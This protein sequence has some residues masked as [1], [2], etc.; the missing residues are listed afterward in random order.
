MTVDGASKTGIFVGPFQQQN[1]ATGAF[2]TTAPLAVFVSSEVQAAAHGSTVVRG[3]ET[4]Y[5]VGIQPDGEGMTALVLS[6]NA[7]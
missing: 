1:F 4:Y 2:E 7:E 6:K 5:V 3:G